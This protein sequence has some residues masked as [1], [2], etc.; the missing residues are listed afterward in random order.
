MELVCMTVL[1]IG[2]TYSATLRAAGLIS[3]TCAWKPDMNSRMRTGQFFKLQQRF[4]RGVS[5]QYPG[6]IIHYCKKL[7]STAADFSK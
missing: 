4:F 2:A 3:L 1:K 6:E 5:Q 7:S